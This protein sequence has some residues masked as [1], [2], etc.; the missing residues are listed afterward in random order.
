MYKQFH[1][2]AKTEKEKKDERKGFVP[3]IT[4][5]LY[6]YDLIS[7][8]LVQISTQIFT[9]TLEEK[10]YGLTYRVDSFSHLDMIV[11]MNHVLIRDVQT[12]Q[13]RNRTTIQLYMDAYS[14][15]GST[16]VKN[17]SYDLY[18][19]DS[20]YDPW[21]EHYFVFPPCSRNKVCGLN[22]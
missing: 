1:S 8:R 2:E 3:P 15:F 19:L 22:C 12:D 18:L 7:K 11:L 17:N 9:V 5:L 20:F 4:H 14:G 10:L 6:S 16:S 21:T 13:N